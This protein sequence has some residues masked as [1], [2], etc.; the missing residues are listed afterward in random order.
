MNDTDKPKD[1]NAVESV[2]DLELTSTQAEEIEGGSFVY[3]N[4][5]GGVYVAT[6]D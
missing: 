4:F 5:R 1:E 3:P 6:S 2:E